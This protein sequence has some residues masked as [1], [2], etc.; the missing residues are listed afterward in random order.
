MGAGLARA[1][2]DGD[3]RASGGFA[4]KA[5]SPARGRGLGEGGARVVDRVARV[6]CAVSDRPALHPHP[7]L[8]LPKEGEGFYGRSAALMRARTALGSVIMSLSRMRN[9]RQPAA[10]SLASRSAS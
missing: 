8:S 4:C 9:V 2:A 10:A 6:H 1:G 7:T 5:L 3:C